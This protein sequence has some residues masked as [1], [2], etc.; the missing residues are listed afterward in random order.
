VSSDLAH[1]LWGALAMASLTAGLLF[2]RSWKLTGE[3]LFAL[4]ALAF[5]VFALNWI[6]LAAANPPEETRHYVFL[7]RL[8]AFLLIIAAVVD[9]N[10]RTRSAAAGR[11]SASVPAVGA[12]N[13]GGG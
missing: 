5:G 3:R 4:F 8:V 11:S 10:R 2:L 9:K 7:L 13:A 1:F 12:R 6:V